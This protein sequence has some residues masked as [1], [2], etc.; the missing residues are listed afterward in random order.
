MSD[1]AADDH[2]P[3]DAPDSDVAPDSE[4]A[5]D[6]EGPDRT[7]RSDG[8]DEPGP[9][10]VQESWAPADLSETELADIGVADPFDRLPETPVDV[11]D[12]LLTD[13][14]TPDG[15]IWSSIGPHEEQVVETDDERDVREV[16]IE[17]YCRDCPHVADPPAFTCTYEGSEIL[18]VPSM[19]V[20]RLADC[21]IVAERDRLEAEW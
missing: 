1:D 3:E 6:G 12:D 7:G 15:D 5:P 17:S 20:V 4:D 10:T 21:P 8:I 16:P 18:A 11:T 2:D 13:A 19:G 14:P 9:D